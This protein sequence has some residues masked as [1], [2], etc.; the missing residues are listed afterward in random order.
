MILEYS[1]FDLED[2]TCS[3]IPCTVEVDDA[4]I[5]KAKKDGL[6]DDLV[7]SAIHN[8]FIEKVKT[9]DFDYCLEDLEYDCRSL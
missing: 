3:E 4:L 7:M 1:I 8:A 6:F 2:G 5:S 9:L